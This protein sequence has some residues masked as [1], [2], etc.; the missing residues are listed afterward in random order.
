M[1]NRRQH[2]RR[3]DDQMLLPTAEQQ[4][5]IENIM[6]LSELEREKFQILLMLDNRDRLFGHIE[7]E[8]P[9]VAEVYKAF[10]GDPDAGTPGIRELV[11]SFKKTE[12]RL[13][14][15]LDG[16][17]FVLKTVIPWGL[18]IAVAIASVGKHVG[19]F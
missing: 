19:W 10:T 4:R 13:N 1:E 7:Q 12:D 5:Q 2:Y 3:E 14:T 9:K 18:G 17:C 15:W 11:L 16:A 8:E 6:S